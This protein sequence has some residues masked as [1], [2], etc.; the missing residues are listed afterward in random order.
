LTHNMKKWFCGG[1][2]SASI[3][4]GSIL[5]TPAQPKIIGEILQSTDNLAGGDCRVWRSGTPQDSIFWMMHDDSALMNISGR[6]LRLKLIAEERP[7]GAAT[8][9]E[10]WTATYQSGKVIV[11]ILWI[12]TFACPVDVARC[13]VTRYA[14]SFK[15]RNGD[16]QETLQAVGDCGS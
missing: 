1:V 4:L 5:P 3:L 6:D 10:R 7:S 11:K 16:R 12:T 8:L 9:G 15:V 14:V 13:E 2:V